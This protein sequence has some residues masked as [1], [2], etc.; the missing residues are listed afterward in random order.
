VLGKSSL[1]R[2]WAYHEFSEAAKPSGEVSLHF[3]Y[4][5]RDVVYKVKNYT[6]DGHCV[7]GHPWYVDNSRPSAAL[8]YDAARFNSTYL[9]RDR[10]GVNIN[11]Y[12]DKNKVKPTLSRYVD[13]IRGG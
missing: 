10:Q 2:R 3:L 9:S 13:A 7:Y 6:M 11:Q 8:R 5:A 1:V 4:P 12:R